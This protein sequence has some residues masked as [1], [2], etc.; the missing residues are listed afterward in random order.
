MGAPSSGPVVAPVDRGEYANAAVHS[1][2]REAALR[3]SEL[4][5]VHLHEA[6]PWALPASS[7]Q[8]H[9]PTKVDRTVE[10]WRTAYPGGAHV[11]SQ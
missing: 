3:R 2:F 10:R 8:I 9:T 11:K 7:T 5:V 6:R 1:A 4:V